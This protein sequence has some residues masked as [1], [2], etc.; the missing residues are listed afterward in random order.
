MRVRFV[1]RYVMDDGVQYIL[2]L[3]GERTV[4]DRVGRDALRS[5]A[6]VA[7]DG[8]DAPAGPRSRADKMTYKGA[9][10]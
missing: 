8:G 7:V 4:P 9:E 1:R 10:Q 3:P 2:I 5:G 6:A